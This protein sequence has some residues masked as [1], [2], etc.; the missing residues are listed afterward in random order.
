MTSSATPTEFLGAG[1]GGVSYSC[2]GSYQ[3]TSDPLSF[4]VFSTPGVVQSSVQFTVSL[5]ISKSAVG[6]SGHPG[7]S[8]WQICYASLSPFTAL[9][10]TSGTAVIGGASYHTGL[11]PD[12]SSTQGA[13]C[14]QARNKDNAGDVVVT[15][16][17]SGDP[18]G[19]G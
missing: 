10:G 7:A 5:E 19:W 15:F 8:S 4:D 6:S 18:V 11:L 1:L 14:V 12:C 9:P 17:A 3:R 16:L 2:G 13:P